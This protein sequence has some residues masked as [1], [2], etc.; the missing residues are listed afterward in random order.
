MSD[1]RPRDDDLARRLE[2]FLAETAPALPAEVLEDV[3]A[4]IPRTPREQTGRIWPRSLRLVPVLGI[5]AAVAVVVSLNLPRVFAPGSS[6]SAAAGPSGSPSPAPVAPRR[7]DPQADF[8][9]AAGGAN[10]APDGYGN[11]DVWAYR[12]G[13][14]GETLQFPA[15][16]MTDYDTE[17]PKWQ[18]DGFGNLFV[19]RSD[20]VLTLHP[21]SD[22]ST[23]DLAAIVT[24][25]SPMQG[26]VTAEGFFRAL[27][28][29]CEVPDSPVEV[30]VHR[31]AEVVWTQ[32]LASGSQ[33][34]RLDLDVDVG[35]T[36]SF[37]VGPR[38]NANC[39]GTDLSL[40]IRTR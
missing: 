4:R 27:Q 33:L 24:W 18:T 26:P 25:T 38:G 40:E 28:R 20:G 16:V 36:L 11:P 39:D 17:L 2:R 37:V 32:T 15:S 23:L 29:P 31:D 9:I 10:P 35:T 5:V 8:V 3:V 19:L 21:W 13:I 1:G 12:Q 7:W 22:G 30:A 6:P 14:V 34:F